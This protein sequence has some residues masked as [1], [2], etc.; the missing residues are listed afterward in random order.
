MVTDLNIKRKRPHAGCVARP[1]GQKAGEHHSPQN[2]GST[3]ML[4]RAIYD[5][6]A[7]PKLNEAGYADRSR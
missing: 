2:S 1:A 3:E 7:S 4:I 5:S 6:A